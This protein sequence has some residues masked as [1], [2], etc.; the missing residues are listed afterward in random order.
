MIDFTKPIQTKAGAPARVIA[1]D[2]DW[3]WVVVGEDNPGVI[4]GFCSAEKTFVNV[5][6]TKAWWVNVYQ[7]GFG[8]AFTRQ[9]GA[10]FSANPSRQ[11]LWKITYT[12]GQQP[13]IEVV[14]EKE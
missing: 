3:I 9:E 10:D 2:G 5:P 7:H 6:E 13:T 11:A 12:K 1:Q 4:Y 8:D 14:W